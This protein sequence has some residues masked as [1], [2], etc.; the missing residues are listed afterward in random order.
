VLSPE[1]NYAIVAV[2]EAYLRATMT[3]R[4]E[5]VGRSL[6]DVFSESPSDSGAYGVRENV[7]LSIEKVVRTGRADIMPLQKYDVSRSPDE[8]GG[9]EERY[10]RP[11]NSPL[12]SA[13][14]SVG[15]VIHR[16]EDVTELVQLKQHDEEDEQ[17]VSVL[18][19]RAEH[20]EA[21]LLLRG[22]EMQD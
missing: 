6:F 1:Q 4:E 11:N 7:R 13:D 16:V 12:F 10:W 18:Q 3:N 15:Y 14:G 2:T 21:E 8:G 17:R 19:S 22:R 20:S 9:F 5:I